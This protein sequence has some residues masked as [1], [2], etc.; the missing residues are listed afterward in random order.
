MLQDDEEEATAT[1][2]KKSKK[3]KTLF[4]NKKVELLLSCSH[5]YKAGNLKSTRLCLFSLVTSA[6]TIQ[7][8]S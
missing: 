7:Y 6:K 2:K 8:Y 5:L 4:G 1:I 3:I